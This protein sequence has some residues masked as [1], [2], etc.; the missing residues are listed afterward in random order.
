M[1]RSEQIPQ[2][3]RARLPR[4]KQLIEQVQVHGAVVRPANIGQ[5]VGVGDPRE[6]AGGDQDCEGGGKGQVRRWSR[7]ERTREEREGGNGL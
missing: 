2:L 5:D 1:R 4:K 7:D 6:E 3:S